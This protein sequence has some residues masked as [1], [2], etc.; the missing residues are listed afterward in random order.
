MKGGFKNKSFGSQVLVEFMLCLVIFLGKI[1]I[2]FQWGSI[3]FFYQMQYD[4]SV[5]CFFC[6][7]LELYIGVDLIFLLILLKI[8]IYCEIFCGP[9]RWNL[10]CN[11]VLGREVISFSNYFLCFFCCNS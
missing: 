9:Q 1:T 6:F 7:Q 4:V 2:H 8:Y 11:M 3:I 5:T 10:L